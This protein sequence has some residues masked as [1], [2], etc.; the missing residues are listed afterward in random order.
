MACKVVAAL[1]K[2]AWEPHWVRLLAQGAD[3]V[4]EHWRGLVTL[5]RGWYAP[6]WDA[7]IV[8]R[9]WH[10]FMGIHPQGTCR[11]KGEAKFRRL[12]TAAPELGRAWGGAVDCVSGEGS[13]LQG[14]LLARWDQSALPGWWSVRSTILGSASRPVVV[15]AD[16]AE[17]I[18]TEQARHFPQAIC[19]L[20][21]AHLWREVRHA[22]GVAA[23]ARSLSARERDYHLHVHRSWLWQGGVD[24]AVQGL[25]DLGTGLPAEPL[26][27]ITKA[28]TYLENQRRWIGSYE[29]WRKLGSPVGSGM[30]ER[31]VTLMINR[32]MKKR[33]MRWCRPHATAMVALRTDLLNDDW[34]TPQRL[35]AFP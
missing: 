33:G 30:I 2:G 22:I 28:I 10:P 6:W 17:W 32:R 15:V 29:D 11:S 12:S 20:D 18:K 26:E 9:G 19:I 1:E 13:R 35:L 23:Q 7:K 27:T 5:A 8:S 3:R 4:P 25:R 16:G 31:A 21:W 34:G 24:Q 14:T